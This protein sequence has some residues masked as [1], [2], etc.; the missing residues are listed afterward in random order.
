MSDPLELAGV[1]L[2]AGRAGERHDEL[3]RAYQPATGSAIEPGYSSAS[4][5][6]LDEAVRRAAEAAPVLVA[7]SG[8]DRATLLR[9]MAD[10]IDAAADA[11]VERAHLETALPRPRLTGEVARTSNQLRLFADVVAEGS[12]VMARIDTAN[13]QRTPPKP[14]IRSMLRPLGPVAVFGASNFPLAF[15]V[16]GGDTAS[17]LAA[18]N[19]VI[20]KAHPAHPGTSE[21][22]GLVLTK[23]IASCGFPAGAFSLLF[24][25][26]T[27]VGAALVLHP[28]IRAV[29][30]TGSFKGG[31][32]MMDL[33]AS[34]EQPIPVYA[35]MGSVNPVFILPGALRERGE[36][37]AAGLHASFTLGGGQ[38]CTK[39]GL[40][41]L[42]TPEAGFLA[43]LRALTAEAPGFAL[44][45]SGIA[46]RYRDGLGERSGLHITESQ[47]AD[48]GFAAQAALLETDYA[49][50][51]DDPALHEELFGP[52]TLLVTGTNRERMLAAARAL[53]GHLTATILGTDADL[54]E[55]AELISI[56][57]T[58]VG[59][60]IYNGFP[61]GVEV[62][63][64]MVHGGPYPATS[65]GRSTS[66]GSQAILRFARPVCYQNLPQHALPAELRDDNPR[67]ILR[68]WNGNRQRE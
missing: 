50:F 66:V 1:S 54:R 33:A 5:A 19:P 49:A 31:R 52:A 57:E 23:A 37:L 27:R 24:D 13:E 40:I 25:A 18:G 22:A 43:K 63:H 44:L 7:S 45:S 42:D 36:S 8:A 59:R 29:G 11:L 39:P 55:Y 35:E 51:T 48:A 65:D 41:F 3:F 62:T 12:W 67:G 28:L 34:R 60:V 26:G 61:T 9:A 10:G 21:I 64:A 56:L 47:R 17:A 2:I 15:S 16:A 46:H 53:R 4:D 58:K 32:A 30:F 38:F 6:E 14:D 68:L 20:V